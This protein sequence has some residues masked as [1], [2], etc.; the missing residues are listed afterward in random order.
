M[1]IL[2]FSDIHFLHQRT[3]TQHIVDNFIHYLSQYDNVP[4]DMLVIGGDVF[5]RDVPFNDPDVTKVFGWIFEV[6]LWCAKKGTYLR[7]LEGTPSHD[8]FQARHFGEIIGNAKIPVNYAY[9]DTV[10]VEKIPE[11]DISILYVN[12]EYHPDTNVTLS[13]VKDR[14]KEA[15]LCQVDIAVMHGFFNFQLP[16]AA[17]KTPRHD[18][19]SYLS[20]VKHYIFIGHHHTHAVYDRIIANGSFDRLAHGQEEPKGFVDATIK[21]GSDSFY[22]IENT[23]A[24]SYITITP[25][26]K[27]I[28]GVAKEISKV[29]SH[30]KIGSHVRLRLPK[31]H[32]AWVGFNVIKQ[33][34][35][36]YHLTKIGIDEVDEYAPVRIVQDMDIPSYIPVTITQSNIVSL[37]LE[38]AQ[39]RN[40]DID[41]DKM[42]KHL[43]TY[44]GEKD[45]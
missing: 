14:M 35:E 4:V 17:T 31:D 23:K 39:R 2:S 3:P 18:E 43:I 32:P 44:V 1:R 33:Q 37:I 6:A 36:F 29:I 34:Y 5:E 15:G 30:L 8:A 45:V 20:L 10:T 40:P 19:V 16:P 21:T 42:K 22:F 13:D 26:S 24:F 11:L 9:I 41:L 25:K 27:H 7:I 38:E 28:E 12:D